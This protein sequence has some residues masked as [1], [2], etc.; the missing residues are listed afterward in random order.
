MSLTRPWIGH[1]RKTCLGARIWSMMTTLQI[2]ALQFISTYDS[3]TQLHI[4]KKTPQSGGCAHRTSRKLS[5]IHFYA[6]AL[7]EYLCARRSQ[8]SCMHDFGVW[9][10]IPWHKGNE[11]S[12][13]LMTH[14]NNRSM[15][16]ERKRVPGARIGERGAT[17]RRKNCLRE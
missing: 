5:S 15:V 11:Q 17:M 10:P 7:F 13:T 3:Y 14:T 8:V 6:S 1:T 2:H 4:K 16:Q 9:T 12:K